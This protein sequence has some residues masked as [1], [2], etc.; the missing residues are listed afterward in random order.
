MTPAMFSRPAL[1]CFA[2]LALTTG[3][4]NLPS[5]PERESPALESIET[6]A[7]LAQ[8]VAN[9]Q[10]RD[11]I[12]VRGDDSRLAV[13]R[14]EGEQVAELFSVDESY[15]GLPPILASRAD[16]DAVL[17]V[18][19]VSSLLTAVYRWNGKNVEDLSGR[20]QAALEAV[21]PLAGADVLAIDLAPSGDVVLAA[22]VQEGESG[23][24]RGRFCRLST[25]GD[26]CE[27][28]SDVDEV[29]G[30]GGDGASEALVAEQEAVYLHAGG[31]LSRRD[32]D[33][34]WSAVTGAYVEQLTILDGG[35]VAYVETPEEDYT[36]VTLHVLGKDGKEEGTPRALPLD[37]PWLVGHSMDGLWSLEVGEG[38]E[39]PETLCISPSCGPRVVWSQLVVHRVTDDV[40]EVAHI[41][42]EYKSS[43]RPDTVSFLPLALAGGALRVEV[44][45]TLSDNLTVFEVE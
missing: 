12:W 6:P 24:R 45:D 44:Q 32:G 36:E 23:E 9:D 38:R 29:Y 13:L 8:L 3:C 40:E 4:N 37:R 15:F 25:A 19:T 14:L 35:R 16:D 2:L 7:V 26:S 17:A 41:N 10:R 5:P 27:P 43:S 39:E 31:R 33:G 20:L 34:A 18:P 21:G 30:G 22:V 28:L 42:R 11:G 1:A